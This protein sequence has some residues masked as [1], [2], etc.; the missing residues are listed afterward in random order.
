MFRMSPGSPFVRSAAICGA[1]VGLL[2]L[3]LVT[4]TGYLGKNSELVSLLPMLVGAA[5]GV[6]IVWLVFG[7]A[8]KLLGR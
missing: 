7:V 4:L 1:F 5:I 8:Q 2:L 3:A 6:A